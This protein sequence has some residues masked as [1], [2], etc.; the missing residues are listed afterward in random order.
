M[1]DL[2][3]LGLTLASGT[4]LV[5]GCMNLNSLLQPL[6]A[7]G[8]QSSQTAPSTSNT[9]NNAAQAAATL[10]AS[11]QSSLKQ[12]AAL[13]QSAALG[14]ITNG[15]V[16]FLK[17]SAAFSISGLRVQ[18][19]PDGFRNGTQT[20]V[21]SSSVYSGEFW[22]RG[23]AMVA[24]GSATASPNA[25]PPSMTFDLFVATASFNASASALVGSELRGTLNYDGSTPVGLKGSVD[26]IQNGVHTPI[27]F[28]FVRGNNN[29]FAWQITAPITAS[30]GT[31]LFAHLFVNPDKTG[32][33]W[34]STNRSGSPVLSNCT[35]GGNG[36]W[37]NAPVDNPS[38]T[39]SFALP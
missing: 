10:Q 37:V 13:T 26:I 6:P 32:S 17:Q 4:L 14:T 36:Q 19:V 22:S 11:L 35:S 16:S 1:R 31:K 28:G 2:R 29:G 3:P 23:G 34:V 39:Q 21:A 33:G 27:D 38:A 12:A 8:N 18:D 9:V 7:T 15:P 5:A 30:D 24:S 25:N 20:T